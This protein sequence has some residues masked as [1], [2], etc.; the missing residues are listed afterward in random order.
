MFDKMEYGY[1]GL[2]LGHDGHTLYYLTGSPLSA[3]SR[4]ARIPKYEAEG[5]HL[6]TYNIATGNYQ[7]MGQIILDNGEAAAAEQALAMGS[8]GTLYSLTDITR[9]GEPRMDLISFRP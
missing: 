4:G 1:L 8:D 7:D 3:N 2:V 5:S 6:V 9:N